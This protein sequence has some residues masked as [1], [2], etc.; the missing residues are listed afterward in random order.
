MKTEDNTNWTKEL[1]RIRSSKKT[2]VLVKQYQYR[3]GGKG[4][5]LADLLSPRQNYF[6]GAK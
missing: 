4:G 3:K 5:K 6:I 2:S 1:Q